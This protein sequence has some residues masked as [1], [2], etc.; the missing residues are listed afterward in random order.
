MLWDRFPDRG[1]GV[2]TISSIVSILLIVDRRVWTGVTP[3][4]TFRCAEFLLELQRQLAD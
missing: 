3:A 4:G 1:E 2:L